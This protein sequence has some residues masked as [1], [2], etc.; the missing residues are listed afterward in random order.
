MDDGEKR[1]GTQR[2]E[3]GNDS[4]SAAAFKWKVN[5]NIG[6]HHTDRVWGLRCKDLP[7]TH[8]L[9]HLWMHLFLL[10]VSS[11]RIPC[12]RVIGKIKKRSGMNQGTWE[13]VRRKVFRREQRFFYSSP[14]LFHFD[15]TLGRTGGTFERPADYLQR[16]K[17]A[18]VVGE[19]LVQSI[20]TDPTL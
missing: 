18:G 14:P 17:D 9:L 10:P 8:K 2:E 12:A 3:N 7:V 11:L 15:S 20:R 1:E 16:N 5:D 4:L 19:D 13:S 6:L